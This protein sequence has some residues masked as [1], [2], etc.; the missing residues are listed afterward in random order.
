MLKLYYLDASTCSLMEFVSRNQ[1]LLVPQ[2]HRR[3][4]KFNH[5]QARLRFQAG[6]I[7][8][9]YLFAELCG[10]AIITISLTALGKPFVEGGA[11]TFNISHADEYVGVAI[12]SGA[13][14]GV[15]LESRLRKNNVMHIAA[16][17]FTLQEN[18]DM[19][20]SSDPQKYFYQ[21]WTLKEAYIKAIGTGLRKPLSEIAFSIQGNIAF[22]DQKSPAIKARFYSCELVRDVLM[23]LCYVA[24]GQETL[25]VFAMDATLLARHVKPALLISSAGICD[26]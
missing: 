22:Y 12:A 7:L 9:R 2:D 25:Q 23:G 13:A 5:L 18:R 17:Y 19:R 3:A 11:Y 20:L 10:Q 4:E 15:D 16:K 14:V 1:Q 8:L 21:L 24:P 26:Q 6:R